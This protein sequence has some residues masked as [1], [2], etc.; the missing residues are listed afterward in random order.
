MNSGPTIAIDQRTPSWKTALA[1]AEAICGEAV[2]AAFT[3]ADIEP[4]EVSIVLA[5]NDF[6]R[7]LNHDH[8]G[9]DRPTDV[10]SFPQTVGPVQDGRNLLPPK[11]RRPRL[12]GDVVVAYGVVAADAESSGIPLRDHLAHM[13]IHGVLHLA[14][15]DHEGDEDARAMEALEAAALARLGIPDPYAAV[16]PPIE[17][18]TAAL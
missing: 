6:I 8:R 7:S 16:D 18:A 11:S 12:F 15:Y 9:L 13:I 3:A 4:G 2:G 1:D 14:G 10:L 17:T 5:D